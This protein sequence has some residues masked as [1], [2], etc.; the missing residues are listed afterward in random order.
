[1]N[2]SIARWASSWESVDKAD[3][4][5]KLFGILVV[6]DRQRRPVLLFRNDWK[7]ESLSEEEKYLDLKPWSKPP[8]F[9]GW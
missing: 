5:G 4:D 6:Q 8:S 9:E 2:Y 3:S 1:M 7:A